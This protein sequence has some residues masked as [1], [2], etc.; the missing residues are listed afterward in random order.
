MNALGFNAIAIMG[1]SL[2][3][4]TRSKDQSASRKQVQLLEELISRAPKTMI[5]I[6]VFMDND[7]PGQNGAR[8]IFNTLYDLCNHHANLIFDFVGITEEEGKR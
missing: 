4:D 3:S 2:A 5:K 1:T 8:R 6:H 7:S